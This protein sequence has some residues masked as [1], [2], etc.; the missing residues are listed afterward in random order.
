[1]KVRQ[2]FAA[3]MVATPQMIELAAVDIER[4]VSENLRQQLHE[5]GAVVLQPVEKQDSGYWSDEP[6]SWWQ[7]LLRRTPRQRWVP[8]VEYRMT[9]FGW[10]DE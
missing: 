2:Q 3:M 7:K 6:R 5:A 9:G 4:F 8:L 1:M 10:V